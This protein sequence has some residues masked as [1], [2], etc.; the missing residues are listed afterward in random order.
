MLLAG[1]AMASGCQPDVRPVRVAVT[2]ID[3]VGPQLLPRWEPLRIDLG[4][5]LGLGKLVHFEVLTPRQIRVHLGSG[6]TAMAIVNAVEYA[7]IEP[8]DGDVIIAAAVNRAGTTQRTGLIVT[9]ADSGIQSLA[10][11]KGKRF[12]FGPKGD[13][14]LDTAAVCHLWKARVRLA[15]IEQDKL[16]GP[17]RYL[18]SN[19]VAKAVA[20]GKPAAGIVDEAEY[21]K[22]PDKGGSV[23]LGIVS[24]DQL[25]ILHRTDP[26]PE[27]AVVCS[28]KADPALVEKLRAYFLEEVNKKPL[29]VLGWLGVNGFRPAEREPYAAFGRLVREVFPPVQPPDAPASEE[30]EATTRP[31]SGS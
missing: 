16:L 14:L 25:R 18:D 21:A 7:E 19:D 5:S 23:L 12:N 9:R 20:Y 31:T 1:L 17:Y 26:V 8:A 10:D 15:D 30:T 28:K 13:P 3:L 24:K 27:V 11:L 29:A 4:L 6:R 2:R 22:W